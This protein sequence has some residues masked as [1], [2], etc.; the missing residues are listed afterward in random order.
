[1]S[2]GTLVKVVGWY[3]N[4]WGYSSR[5]VD[6]TQHGR[7]REP[8][9]TVVDLPQL[10]DLGPLDGK[11]VLVRTDFNVPLEDGRIT[12]DFR[13][14][15]ALPTLTWLQEQGATVVACSHLGRP[16]GPAQ[17]EVLDGA[18]ARPSWPSWRRASSC[19]RTS[20]STRA[21]RATIPPF[22]ARLVE[23]MDAYVDDAFGAAHR[24]H[25]SIVGPPRTLPERR[26]AAS[27][28]RRS[29]C[30]SASATHPKRPFVAVLGGAKVSDKIGVIDA[31]LGVVDALVIGGGMCFTFLGGA[32]LPGRRL[33]VRGRPGGDVRAAPRRAEADP[34][35]RG[36]RRP[37][38][39]RL[40]PDV[41]QAAA[42]RAARAS[43]SAP[44]PRRPSPTW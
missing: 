8:A 42:R 39:R 6:L 27:W 16:E 2:Q 31:L 40:R 28:P 35:A 20:G 24:A 33:A 12:D 22:V 10:E 43:T 25:A 41:G 11:R 5:T 17:P 3:D 34:P 1:M 19:W 30:C 4:E 18:R 29:R 15:A 21:R 23:G 38:R 37:G 7:R 9:L 44:A 14:R 13:I 36:H 32:G 26:P